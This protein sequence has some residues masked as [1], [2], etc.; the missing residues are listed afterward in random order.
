[1]SIGL[2]SQ[3][4]EVRFVV[5]E[6][7][8]LKNLLISMAICKPTVSALAMG[9]RGCRYIFCEGIALEILSAPGRFISLSRAYNSR[10]SEL[11][12]RLYSC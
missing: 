5:L 9:E 3:L 8:V 2:T 6:I 4:D 11:L 12:P 1:M 10:L 7:I